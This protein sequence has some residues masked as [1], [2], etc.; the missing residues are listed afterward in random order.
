M[1]RTLVMLTWRSLLLSSKVC[2]IKCGTFPPVL[3]YVA[4]LTSSSSAHIRD[5][6]HH[7]V[8]LNSCIRTPNV[9]IDLKV[10]MM[11]ALFKAAF[12]FS[13]CLLFSC[14]LVHGLGILNYYT[15]THEINIQ[16]NYCYNQ[17]RR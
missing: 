6:L 11:D 15:N 17:E 10:E 16:T 14:K 9:R 8:F 1:C 3:Q 13:Y 2:T 7:T 4:A 5:R 12:V